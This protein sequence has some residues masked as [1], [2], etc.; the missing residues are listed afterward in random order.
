NPFVFSN[1]ASLTIDPGKT[2][3][4]TNNGAL[5]PGAFGGS[6]INNGTIWK[7]TV[8][9]T[10]TI[11]V[12]ITMLGTSTVDL[13]A[14]TLQFGGGADV[15]SGATIDIAA[16]TTLEVTGGVFLFSSGPVSMPGSGTFKVSGGTLRVPTSITMTIPNVT[17][18]VSGVIDGGG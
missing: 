1:G 17:L 11:G 3:S 13:D 14:G 9:G 7:K 4:I 5:T 8:A 2:L 16:G 18:Q 12:P 10:S 15:A 6:V